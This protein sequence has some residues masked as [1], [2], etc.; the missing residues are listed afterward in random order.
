MYPESLLNKFGL[1][2]LK[3][4]TNTICSILVSIYLLYG[5]T[6]FYFQGMS[7][8]ALLG[9]FG[10]AWF[11]AILQ[12]S[13]QY[14]ANALIISISIILTV[15][16]CELLLGHLTPTHR[17]ATEQ[18]IALAQKL[19]VP[20]DKRDRKELFDSI[21]SKETIT[22]S[23]S[24]FLNS[25][26]TKLRPVAPSK[27]LSLTY[28]CNESG[29]YSTFFSD[30]YGFNNPDYIWDSDRS[31][32]A[33]LGDSFAT[34]SCVKEEQVIARVIEKLNPDFDLINLGAN[35]NGPLLE[36]AALREFAPL[37]KPELVIWIYYEGNDL[38]NFRNEL[39]DPIIKRYFN[40]EFSQNLASKNVAL[41]LLLDEY[42]SKEADK[43][44]SQK[45]VAADIGQQ[46]SWKTRHIRLHDIRK[47]I[48][49]VFF[50]NDRTL[51]NKS[52]MPL[53]F[54]VLQE[55]KNE[56]ES[57]GG[58]IVFAYLP[59]YNRYKAPY[60]DHGQYKQKTAILRQLNVMNIRTVDLHKEVFSKE[61]D[62]LTLF[63]FRTFGH[64]T[65]DGYHK[66]ASV[67]NAHIDHHR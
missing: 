24:N 15:Y 58:T 54:K 59:E 21:T 22:I 5:I 26:D 50:S 27:P 44:S 63:P 62:P 38:D 10:T 57:W 47:K 36:L 17:T 16:S 64:Y 20:F 18:R 12:I 37:K 4:A 43:N 55:A 25:R 61:T 3:N 39:T 34:G 60:I 51:E 23:P 1:E 46:F 42:I 19:G 2:M 32:I 31:S 67:L 6:S 41:A 7:A 35:G 33:T 29:S 13:K 9:V 65:A 11:T 45:Q 14:R 52:V 8:G 48:G 28:N 30:R 56:V 40:K 66:V 53:F 49:E